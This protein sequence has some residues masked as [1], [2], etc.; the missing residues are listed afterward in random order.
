MYKYIH[1]LNNDTNVQENWLSS[2]V[3][4]IEKDEKIGMVGSKLVYSNGQLQEA[5]TQAKGLFNKGVKTL[6]KSL[7]RLEEKTK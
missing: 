3:E 6:I 7:E 5:G 1:F 2:L 4:L